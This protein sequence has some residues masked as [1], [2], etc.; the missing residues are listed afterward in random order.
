LKALQF[1]RNNITSAALEGCN[2]QFFRNIVIMQLSYNVL[3]DK[4]FEYLYNMHTRLDL[5]QML[6]FNSNDLTDKGME[7]LC[8][9]DMPQLL[10]LNIK[11]T[12]LSMKGYINFFER[13]I[14]SLFVVEMD[15]E[16]IDSKVLEEYRSKI[17]FFL[18]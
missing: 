2:S 14:S 17:D 6:L 8:K 18:V 10:Y 13:N 9:L 15:V 1:I 4:F 3:D 12:N 7:F 5:L 11:S 16:E